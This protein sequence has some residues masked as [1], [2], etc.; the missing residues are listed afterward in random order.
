MHNTYQ[1]EVINI[2][3]FYVDGSTQPKRSP[4]TAIFTFRVLNVM[5]DTL[6]S[7]VYRHQR[8]NR[9]LLKWSLKAKSLDGSFGHGIFRW[10]NLD[11]KWSIDYLFILS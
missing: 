2:E 6:L 4:E 10:T 1:A 5:E 7:G 11:V 9:Q 8:R 3:L